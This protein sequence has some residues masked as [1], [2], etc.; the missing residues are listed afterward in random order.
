MMT[1]EYEHHVEYRGGD[2]YRAG[3]QGQPAIA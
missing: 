3:N 2:R 1:T